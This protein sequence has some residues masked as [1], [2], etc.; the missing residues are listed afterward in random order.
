M[1]VLGEGWYDRGRDWFGLPFRESFSEAVLRIPALFPGDRVTFLLGSA[2]A[3]HTHSQ[4]ASIEWKGG[5][6]ECVLQPAFPRTGWQAV[7]IE[8]GGS[9]PDTGETEFRFRTEAWRHADYEDVADYRETGILLGAVF[10][11]SGSHATH[12]ANP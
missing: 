9:P 4:C 10:V 8:S 3:W 6:T 12:T 7:Q 11:E 1:A 2:K 5:R